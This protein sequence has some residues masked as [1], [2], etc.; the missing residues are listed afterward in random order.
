M[1]QRYLFL[2]INKCTREITYTLTT[3]QGLLGSGIKIRTELGESSDLTVLG[4]EKLERTS[5][6]LHSLELG[7]GTD[8]RDGKTDV[9]GR[10]DTLVE[11]LGLQED[12]AVGDGNNVGRNVSRHITTLGL[13]DGEGSQGTATVGLVELGS[14]LEET[15][16]KVENITGVGLTTGGT[17]EQQRHLAVSNGLL[18]KIVV[19]HESVLSI[20]TEPLT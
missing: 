13:N 10:S 2:W 5:D 18:G 17:T 3:V 16:V 19:D 9:D 12:L 8:T 6:L 15:R 20:I 14:T 11:Q 1:G 4:Q 7:S